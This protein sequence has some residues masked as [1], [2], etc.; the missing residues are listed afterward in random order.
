M[1]RPL[2]LALLAACGVCWQVTPAHAQEVPTLDQL[3]AVP[4]N[5]PYS[6]ANTRLL[7]QYLEHWTSRLAEAEDVEGMLGARAKLVNGYQT[8]HRTTRYQLWYAEQAAEI[9]T[10]ALKLESPARQIQAA[11]ALSEMAQITIQPALEEMASSENPA[12]RYW[13]VRGYRNSRQRMLELGEY[14][15]RMLKT[16]RRIGLN[17]DNYRMVAEVLAALRPYPGIGGAE[18]A[19]IREAYSEIWVARLRQVIDGDVDSLLA[20]REE[21]AT[22]LPVNRE[23]RETVRQLLADLL[24]ATFRGFDRLE[25]QPARKR[26]IVQAAME[27]LLIALEERL[28]DVLEEKGTPVADVLNNPRIERRLLMALI[29]AEDVWLVGLREAGFKPRRPAEPETRPGTQPA[30]RPTTTPAE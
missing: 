10:R 29:E 1:T 6:P 23:D 24:G 20:Y 5:G 16:L 26:P 30:T 25:K 21:L 4:R 2:V 3:R 28:N 15:S 19:A 22:L 7:R 8:V 18:L 14:R 11:M 12:V 17:A 27:R 9:V 13:A